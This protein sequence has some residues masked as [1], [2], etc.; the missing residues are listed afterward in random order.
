M[1]LFKID[2]TELLEITYMGEVTVRFDDG[3]TGYSII[4]EYWNE[5]TIAYQVPESAKLVAIVNL[6]NGKLNQ[7]Q[8]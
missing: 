3:N 5:N 1:Y 7:F 4:S 8:L 2:K 6:L